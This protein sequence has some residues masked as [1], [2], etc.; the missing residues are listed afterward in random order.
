MWL[1][2]LFLLW[3]FVLRRCLK[4]T[5]EGAEWASHAARQARLA[6]KRIKNYQMEEVMGPIGALRAPLPERAAC[7][8]P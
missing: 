1:L 3:H 5:T 8:A 6:I 4:P 2:G 7:E